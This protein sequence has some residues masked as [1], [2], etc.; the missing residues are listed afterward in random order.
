VRK[1][2][3]GTK[4]FHHPVVGDLTV[5]F[6]SL[7]VGDNLDQNLVAYT[8][9]PNSPSAE[10]LGLLASWAATPTD[11][12]AAPTIGRATSQAEPATFTQFE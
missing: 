6:E 11:Q 9:E 8:V 1:H 4:H 12:E 2:S 7:Y 5:G 10:A 3:T